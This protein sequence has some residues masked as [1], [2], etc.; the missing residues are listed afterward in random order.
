MPKSFRFLPLFIGAFIFSS[1]L[2]AQEGR[3]PDTATVLVFDSG[4]TLPEGLV[5]KGKIKVIDGGFKTNCGY[6]QTLKESKI[7]ARKAG[8]NVIHITDLKAPDGFSTCYR[9]R[10]DVYF[11]DNITY[12][13][14]EQKRK[15]DSILN[16]LVPD[17]AS[18]A[19]LYVYRPA[20]YYGSLISYQLN[21]DDQPIGRVPNG[22]AYRVKLYK[23]GLT[24]IWAK[25]EA[26]ISKTIDVQ[27]G[28]A[29]FLR[30]SVQMGVFVGEPQLSIVD[31]ARGY[32]GYLRTREKMKKTGEDDFVYPGD[33]R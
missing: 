15:S 18:Y 1:S 6:D 19:V 30:C 23:E 33:K 7:K 28:K 5:P 8:A 14:E 16:S 9:L 17:T 12:Y 24:E 20:S 10:A 4:E 27:H 29:Y 25:T 13:A 32:K 2:Q 26:R 3:L 31:A 22:A 11:L 21:A